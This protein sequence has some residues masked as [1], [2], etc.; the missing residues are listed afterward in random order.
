[1]KLDLT[2]A[3]NTVFIVQLSF[4]QPNLAVEKTAVQTGWAIHLFWYYN[5]K[6]DSQKL[7][8]CQEVR[9]KTDRLKILFYYVVIISKT[10]SIYKC[11]I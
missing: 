7:H 6:K 2:S 9:M 11:S 1:L 10:Y 5:D 4:R 3:Q 8:E